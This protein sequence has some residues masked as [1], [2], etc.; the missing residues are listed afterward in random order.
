MV[1]FFPPSLPLS[2]QQALAWLIY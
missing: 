1:G 2:L